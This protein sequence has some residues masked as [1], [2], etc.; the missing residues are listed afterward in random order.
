MG[1]YNYHKFDAEHYELVKFDG[2]EMGG[3][4]PDGTVT[5][6]NGKTRKLL[7]FTGPFLVLEFGSITCPLF[8]SRRKTMALLTEEFPDVS[9]VVVYVREAHPGNII[10]SHG[11]MDEKIKRGCQLRDADGEGREILIDTMDGGIH[12]AYGSYP[13]AAY[14]INE[15]GCVV[16]RSAWNNPRGTRKALRKLMSGKSVRA[17]SMFLPATP[18]VAIA[19]FKQAGQGSARDFF[20]GLPRLAWN[21]LIRRNLRLLFGRSVKIDPNIGC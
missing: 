3:K 15:N 12:A 18:T 6:L 4:A 13:N 20:R 16:Y 1:D 10:S 7:E 21:N 5:G 2:P 14:I 8:Q 11:D 9:S 17:E 19:T